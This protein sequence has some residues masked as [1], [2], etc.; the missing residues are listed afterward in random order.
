MAQMKD[1][2]I[3]FSAD[4]V[5]AILEGRKTHTR[6]VMKQQPYTLRV[7]GFGYPTKEGGFVSLRSEHCLNECPY[8][9]P[10]DRLWVRETW[11]GT[12]HDTDG[13]ENMHI[14]Y[15]AD[16]SERFVIA[17]ED[18]V[19]PK[20]ATKAGGWVSPLFIKRFASRITLEI[21]D[22]RVQRLQEIS[23]EDCMAEGIIKLPASGRYVSGKGAQYFGGATSTA[24]SAF[25]DLW[26]AINGSGSWDAN[27]WV[28][29]ITFRRI[30]CK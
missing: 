21:T 4:M 27:P 10:G 16:G 19:L 18:Y 25:C 14:S 1:R 29:A 7:E 9:K 3:I 20:A 2:P 5:K 11:T 15:A 24:K 23:S 6:R 26:R 28:W 22:V 30:E 8:G 13:L 12:W 17:P